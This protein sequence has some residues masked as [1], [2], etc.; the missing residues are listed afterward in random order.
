VFN[1]DSMSFGEAKSVAMPDPLMTY[2][3]EVRKVFAEE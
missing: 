3:E 1:W 2:G